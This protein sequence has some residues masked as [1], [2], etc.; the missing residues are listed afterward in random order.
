MDH[1]YLDSLRRIMQENTESAQHRH[2]REWPSY[3]NSNNNRNRT[4]PYT[5]S[6]PCGVRSPCP[7]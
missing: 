6:T 2:A 3:S 7:H 4:R 1:N 5:S